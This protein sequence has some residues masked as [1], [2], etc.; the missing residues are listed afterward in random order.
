MALR[1]ACSGTTSGRGTIELAVQVCQLACVLLLLPALTLAYIA[2]ATS[3]EAA[4]AE[5]SGGAATGWGRARRQSLAKSCSD[6]LFFDSGKDKK[7]ILRR[8]FEKGEMPARAVATG[9]AEASA[10][11]GAWAAWCAAHASELRAAGLVG[12]CLLVPVL[13]AMAVFAAMRIEVAAAREDKD[14]Y[15]RRVA[16]QSMRTREKKKNK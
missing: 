14:K 12:L 2:W 6:C 15:S 7:L 13:A 3:G 5:G 1:D 11:R 8:I 16:S 10:A 9:A 4:A